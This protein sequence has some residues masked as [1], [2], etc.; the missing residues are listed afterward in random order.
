[1]TSGVR[2][3]IHLQA[4]ALST[5][6]PNWPVSNEVPGEPNCPLPNEVPDEQCAADSRQFSWRVL[7]PV[8]VLIVIAIVQ[9]I[10]A[11]TAE[12]SPWK[13]G[14]FGMFATTDGTAFRRIRVFVEAPERS[15]E[16]EIAPSQELQAARAQL[17]PSDS[18]L[19]N[20][21]QVVVSREQRYGRPVQRVKL[22]V[23]RTEFL[24]GSLEPTERMLREITV[25]EP[26]SLNKTRE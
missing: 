15:E 18:M 22:E 8:V 24:A 6:E 9:V 12:L 7:A 10:L 25:N 23:W 13:G 19:T 17:F 20:L 3:K 21:A 4:P 5:D 16:I 1:M 11:K 14:G 2:Q 26:E